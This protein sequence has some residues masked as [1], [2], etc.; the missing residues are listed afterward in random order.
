M[1]SLTGYNNSLTPTFQPGVPISANAL[2]RLAQGYEMAKTTYSDGVLYTAS[3]GG[4]SY[5]VIPQFIP[6]APG[7]VQ[8]FQVNVF[9]KPKTGG[10][11]DWFIQIGAGYV[12]GGY[13]YG[14][15]D[16]SAGSK[17]DN[18]RVGLECFQINKVAV[19]QTSSIIPDTSGNPSPFVNSGAK[20][21][22]PDAA[23][24]TDIPDLE[25]CIIRNPYPKTN[26]ELPAFCYQSYPY[27]AVI[28]YGSD[29]DS[30]TQ[31]FITD[32]GGFQ[33][34]LEYTSVLYGSNVTIE[35][36]EPGHGGEPTTLNIPSVNYPQ[37]GEN[38]LINYNCQ[39]LQIAQVVWDSENGIW[40]VNQFALGTLAMPL[41]ITCKETQVLDGA[42]PYSTNANYS[43]NQ[44]A[45]YS[46]YSGSD[47]NYQNATIKY[48]Y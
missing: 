31:P 17:M 32:G 48:A 3:S 41:E 35:V 29:A 28:Q 19:S 45:W 25:V 46:S 47:V 44:D 24:G 43:S 26:N 33:N 4:V 20:I 12:I 27:L 11:V 16:N 15:I 39:R 1:G 13:A 34:Y 40:Y 10:G 30:K 8:Q 18:T 22:L 38:H 14:T 2:N 9:S 42:S 37:D 36:Y 21:K 23:I 5:S 7:S 6:T